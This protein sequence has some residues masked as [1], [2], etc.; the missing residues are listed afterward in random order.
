MITLEYTP[1]QMYMREP[2]QKVILGSKYPTIYG[3]WRK[4]VP[5]V[6]K[7]IVDYDYVEVGLKQRL[8]LGLLGISEYK[9]FTGNFITKK[10]LQQIDYKFIR[11]GDPWVFNE[12]TR[13]FQSLDSTF[14]VFNTFVEGHYLHEFYGALINKI[15]YLKKLKLYEIAGSGALYVPERKLIYFELFAGL[16]KPFKFFG[17]KFKLGVYVVSSIANQQNNP[18]QFKIGVQHYDIYRNRWE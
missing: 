16:E 9:I 2:R 7:S 6:L 4:G 3:T 14:P 10:N 12:P 18:F 17:E 13:N 15:P 1:R 5:G 8:K 11:R